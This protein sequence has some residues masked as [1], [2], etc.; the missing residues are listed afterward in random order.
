M[1]NEFVIRYGASGN[2][3]DAWENKDLKVKLVIKQ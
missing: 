3:S 1:N 2:G